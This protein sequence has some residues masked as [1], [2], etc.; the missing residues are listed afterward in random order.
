VKQPD[1]FHVLPIQCASRLSLSALCRDYQIETVEIL[2]LIVVLLVSRSPLS[3]FEDVRG[4]GHRRV[5]SG[6]LRPRLLKM[7]ISFCS[8]FASRVR[9]TRPLTADQKRGLSNCG[10]IW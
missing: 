4:V 10:R 8:F 6:L 1:R 9:I 5:T 2:I 7:L 3:T